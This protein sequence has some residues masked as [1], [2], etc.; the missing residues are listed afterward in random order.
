[1]QYFHNKIV[2]CTESKRI[3]KWLQN[4]TEDK[5]GE[6]FRSTRSIASFNNITEDRA[7]YPCSKHPK[8]YLSTGVKENLW[9]IHDRKHK[10]TVFAG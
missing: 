1:M 6:K 10:E 7:C 2:D 4:H 3:F 9:S 5:E 8:I